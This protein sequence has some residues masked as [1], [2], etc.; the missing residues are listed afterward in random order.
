M[1]FHNW[2]ES[3]NFPFL[4]WYTTLFTM[5]QFVHRALECVLLLYWRVKK[6][7]WS[8]NNSYNLIIAFFIIKSSVLV[9]WTK[10]KRSSH[11]PKLTNSFPLTHTSRHKWYGIIVCVWNGALQSDLQ[12]KK[13]LISGNQ[14]I[15]QQMVLFSLSKGFTLKGEMDN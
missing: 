15:S 4:P 11:S 9:W 3:C 10:V 1:I 14:S 2:P 13:V 7:V 6:S 12:I 8:I 5:C